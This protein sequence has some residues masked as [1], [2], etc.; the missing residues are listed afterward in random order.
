MLEV[1]KN[2]VLLFHLSLLS[3]ENTVNLWFYARSLCR[4]NWKIQKIKLICSRFDRLLDF[5]SW[6]NIESWSAVGEKDVVG[7]RPFN[8]SPRRDNRLSKKTKPKKKHCKN[9]DSHRASS[10]KSR[11]DLDGRWRTLRRVRQTVDT[12]SRL[13]LGGTEHF[14]S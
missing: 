4:S 2:L 6:Q 1:E 7:E 11:N 14:R 5:F 9:S 8:W 12:D 10:T 13:I 3:F